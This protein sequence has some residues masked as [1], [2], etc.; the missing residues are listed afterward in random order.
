MVDA[1]GG[2]PAST[3]PGYGAPALQDGRPT[4]MKSCSPPWQGVPTKRAPPASSAP[5]CCALPDGRRIEA[6]GTCP[7]VITRALRGDAGFGYDPLFYIPSQGKTFAQ[8]DAATKNA[9]SH[10]GR[11]IQEFMN[12][13]A[14]GDFHMLTSKQRAQLRAQSDRLETTLMIGK[15]GITE[16]LI[17]SAKAQLAARELIKGRVLETAMLTAREACDAL[18]AALNAEGVQTI[19]SKFV[20][21][22]RKREKSPNRRGKAAQRRPGQGKSC[23]QGRPEPPPPGKRAPRA[24]ERLFPRSGHPGGD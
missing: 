17:A 23:P 7:G 16:G 20:I 19:G 21:Y 12:T 18:C 3:P 24:E 9:L 5:C 1:L 13:T 4:A 8:L 15:E 14:K 2:L 6:A 10:R 11:A 22:K